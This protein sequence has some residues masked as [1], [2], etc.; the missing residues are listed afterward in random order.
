MS[1]DDHDDNHDHD[2]PHVQDHEV[3]EALEEALELDTQ[4]Q[5]FLEMR[6][7]N[8]ELLRIATEVAGYT[9]EH[10]PLKQ[11]DM[12]NALRNIWEVFSEFYTWV[13]PEEDE[14]DDEDDDID[15][16]DDD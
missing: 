11:S 7:Q 12:R 4:S 6:R 3:E 2:H 5:I 16:D 15:E 14:E 13:D 1:H 10:G 9:G 8:L